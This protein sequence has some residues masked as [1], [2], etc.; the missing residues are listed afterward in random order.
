MRTSGGLSRRLNRTAVSLLCLAFAMV[1]SLPIAFCGAEPPA[2]QLP[3]P[4]RLQKLDPQ[5]LRFEP[6]VGQVRGRGRVQFVSHGKGYAVF[7]TGDGRAVLA[8]RKPWTPNSELRNSKA[9]APASHREGRRR[10]GEPAKDGRRRRDAETVLTLRL[11]GANQEAPATGAQQLP[12][13]SNYFLGNDP[14]GWRTHVP[15]FG[16]I[17]YRTVYP[18]VDLIYYG[19]QGQLEYD[20]VVAPGSDPRAIRL[21]ITVSESAGK[22]QPAAERSEGNA[23]A[24]RD[25]QSP[26]GTRLR[27]AGN[28]DLVVALQDGEV[29]FHKPVVYQPGPSFPPSAVHSQPAANQTQRSKTFLD[30]QF[31][32]KGR[33]CIAFD[34]PRYDRTRPLVI[35]P[36]IAYSTYLGGTGSE[37]GS[38]IAVDASGSA[39]VT[40]YTASTDFPLQGALQGAKA[41]GRDVFISKFSPGGNTLI[42]STYLGGGS[43]DVGLGIA[44]DAAGNPYVT[45]YTQST[46]F[47]TTPGALR[48]SNAG[49]EDAFVTKLNATGDALVYSTYLGGSNLDQAMGIAV[50]GSGNAY[51]AG[52][53][54][55]TDFPTTPGAYSRQCGTDG[56]CNSGVA[57][58]FVSE[59]NASGSA[60]VYSTYL[61]GSNQDQG[62]AVAVDSAGKIYLT[63]FTFS[64]DFPVTP[65]ALDGS[66]GSDGHCNSGVADAFVSKLDP[67]QSGAASLVYSTYLGGSGT[68]NGLGIAVDSAGKA[69]VTGL[70][71]STDFPTTPGA[72]AT[73]CKSCSAGFN[74]AFV[75]KID[76]QQSGPASLLYS[77]YL[78]GSGNDQGNA[79]AVD[80]AG[81]AYVAGA[82]DSTDFPTVDP[83]QAANAG[84]TDAFVTEMAA[85]GNALVTSSYLGGAAIDVGLGIAV[86]KASN[87]Y[88]TGQTYSNNFPVVHSLPPPNN[89]LQG[90]SDAFVAKIGA[91]SGVLLSPGSLSFGNQLVGTNSAPQALQLVNSTGT[92]LNIS[93]I[94]ISGANR[95]DFTQTNTCGTSLPPNGSCTLNVAFDPTAMG[96]R[97]ATLMVTDDGPG[98]PQTASLSGTGIAPVVT[99]NPAS[100]NFG[101]QQV[102]TSSPPQ[103]VQLSNTGTAPLTITSITASI[104]YSQTSNCGNS[105]DVGANCDISVTFS[106]SGVGPRNGTLSIADNAPNSPQVV[107]ASGS[108]VGPVASLSPSSLAFGNQTLNTTSP[109][110]PVTLSNTGNQALSISSIALAGG[111]SGDFAQT[112]DCGASLAPNASCT[113]NVTFTPGATG[114]RTSTLTVTDN[115]AGSPQTVALG[116]TGTGAGATLS[117]T[118]LT[119]GNQPVGSTSPPQFVT[120]TNTGA[121]TLT[122][123]NITTTLDFTQMN[124]CGS[125]VPPG[126]SCTLSVSFAPSGTGSRNGTL[127]VADNAPGSPQSV[128]LSGVGTAPA[129]SLTP[130]SLSFS[131]QGI[132]TAS[133]PQVVVLAN[134]GNAPLTISRISLVGTDASDFSQTNN[135][136]PTLNPGSNCTISVTFTPQ[137]GGM[138]SAQL[139][140]SDNAASSPQVITLSGTGTGA[141][142][143]LVPPS[144]NFG[145]LPVGQSSSPQVA[146]L[147]NVGTLPVAIAELAINGASGQSFVQTNNCGS[148]L[149]PGGQCTITITFTP[150]APG[151]LSATLTVSDNAPGSPQSVAL[152]GVGT[153]N[154]PGVSLSPMQLLFSSQEVGTTSS[155]QAVILTNVGNMGLN[156]A[157]IAAS[158][159]FAQV[160][161]CPRLVLAPGASCQIGVTFTPTAAGA[162][163][164]TLSITDNAFG[165]PHQIPLAGTGTQLPGAAPLV[166]LT[167]SSLAFGGQPVGSASAVQIVTLSNAGTAALAISS[168]A[169]AGDFRQTNTCGST[170]P[171]NARCTLSVTFVPSAGGTRNGTL[172]VSDNASGSPQSVA[173]TGAGQDFLLDASPTSTAINAG[174]TATY[175]LS[176]SSLGGLTGAV[177]LACSGTP[178]ESSCSISPASVTLSASGSAAATM[179]VTTTSRSFAL[180]H[181]APPL[182]PAGGPWRIAALLL[183]LLAARLSVFRLRPA[184]AT[185]HARVL[186][187]LLLAGYLAAL[188]A[189]GGGGGGVSLN[190][191]G[192]I[193]GTPAGSYSLTVT[194]TL[195]TASDPLQHT[196]N[197]NLRVN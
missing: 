49:L 144:L 10:R 152:A 188:I 142:V 138:R 192:T 146:T 61:G 72:Y 162:R 100:L 22:R 98:S 169:V 37:Q 31:V 156:I 43:D 64:P 157:S 128:S 115:A 38:A 194:G 42:Y 193:S 11:M 13:Y 8:L 45:G 27:V 155:A 175:R 161:N 60:L 24:F 91:A 77:T 150:A 83:A 97:S 19:N 125:S 177:S 28:G 166:S 93:S 33:N 131:S 94:Q 126:G 114:T 67:A 95:S 81:N 101:N 190:S 108:G 179:T 39:Y 99:L 20:F 21:A 106:P 154:A 186:A 74:D 16:R 56:T 141:A 118:T 132:G 148:S 29:R 107:T 160:N 17:C 9:E 66:C 58:A 68:D 110:Q 163:N 158:G 65:N 187:A 55:S 62:R 57:D 96:L 134:T 121:A 139:S 54:F 70:T 145:T 59:L 26:V 40:G 32:L 1:V 151:T 147:S 53:T 124:N 191:G 12:G 165:S 159:D 69:Y 133:T 171:P 25:R 92:T 167:P 181:P 51:L 120:L 164:G 35:D 102:G 14:A 85:A 180:P 41:G 105:L 23:F 30:G 111:N 79:I 3:N 135:C 52:L 47:P 46:N 18:G 84:A 90:A 4:S 184:G 6:N 178:A 78:G 73:T 140:V 153:G 182:V 109:P 123:T 15:G 86:D 127:L 136:S 63:G 88:V 76:A 170:L 113:I 82:T 189:C 104:D 195:N 137:A 122:I 185:R 130:G 172:T 89:M 71:T 173:L 34:I 50:D 116:G 183:A 129:V 44:I 174:T 75:S 197:L 36:S 103:N 5:P 168:I 48:T 117:P 143:T 2:P 7:L 87:I 196:L 112:N 176:V 149:G 119:F 80:A